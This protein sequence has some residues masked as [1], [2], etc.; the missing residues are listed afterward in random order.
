MSKRYCIVCG[1]EILAQDPS[2]VF[3]P[4]HGGSKPALAS[5]GQ[6]IE[7]TQT[8]KTSPGNN[9]V[10]KAEDISWQ[11]GQTLLETYKVIGLLGEGGMG[12][13]YHVHHT[14]WDMNLAVKQPRLSIFQNEKG[15]QNF[16]REAETWVNLGLY[17]HITSCYYVRS[18]LNIPHIFVE[19]LAGGSLE[20]WIQQREYDLYAGTK[21]EVLERILDIAVQFAWGLA[22]AHE[23]GLVHQ[24]VKP[25]NVLMTP[26][27][28]VKVTDFGLAKARATAGETSNNPT[29]ALVSGSMHTLAYR[30]PE[31][32]RGEPLDHK[33][34]IW[35][36]AISVLEMF[37]GGVNWIDGQAA[38]IS[39]ET[40]LQNGTW[41]K[42]A[43]PPPGLVSLLKDCFQEHPADRPLD[44]QVVSKRLCQIYQETFL[45]PYHREKPDPT[46]LRSNSLNNKALTMLD[47]GHQETA[48]RL[49]DQALEI[50]N[51]H[52]DAVYNQ[53]LLRWRNGVQNDQD[54]RAALRQI[55][56]DHPRN[57]GVESAFGWVY[58]EGGQ[59]GEALNHFRRAKKF[60]EDFYVDRGL[61][62]IE[63]LPGEDPNIRPIQYEGHTGWV[64]SVAFS[65][66]DLYILSGSND[67]TL[68]LWDTQTTDCI[69]TFEGH[70]KKIVQ[71]AFGIDGHTAF[72]VGED[73]DIRVWNLDSGD[74]IQQLRG[75]CIAVSP[76]GKT[77]LSASSQN[78]IKLWDI[79]SGQCLMMMR[80]HTGGVNALD[81]SPDGKYALSA[82][83]D[84]TIKLWDLTSGKCLRTFE[85][86]TYV[87]C[88]VQFGPRGEQA[89][90]GSWDST[91]RLW[92]IETGD[93]LS[94]LTGHRQGVKATA[95]HPTGQ[96]ALSAGSDR[97]LRLWDLRTQRCLSTIDKNI[98]NLID[99]AIS[100]DGRVALC[101][102]WDKVIT[103]W[104]LDDLLKARRTAP[105]R[106]SR[107]LSSSE[108]S[109]REDEHA[110]Y[111]AS[112]RAHLERQQIAQALNLIEK[113]NSIQGFKNN[114]ETMDLLQKAGKHC[115]RQAFIDC[116]IIQEFGGQKG[117]PY[118][119]SFTPDS[120]YLFSGNNYGIVS[121]W[122]V[123]TGKCI[124]E[125]EAED[126][127]G[128]R[129]IAICPDG[130]Y[131][132]TGSNRSATRS[133]KGGSLIRIWE[134]KSGKC[135][136]TLYGHKKNVESLA[137]SPD[138]RLLLSGSKDR[139]L[140]LW[141]GRPWKCLRSVGRHQGEVRA[142][143]FSPD[144]SYALSG[145]SD[146]V[147][148]LGDLRIGKSIKKFEGHQGSINS[149][150][151][152]PDGSRILSG[153]WDKTV[154]LWD[155]ETA[156]CLHTFEDHKGT[157][158]DVGFSPDGR[159]AFS[160][161]WDTSLMIWDLDK[162]KR[163]HLRVKPQSKHLCAAISPDGRYLI[164]ERLCLMQLQWD[165]EFPGWQDWDDRARPY[166]ENFLTIHTPYSA[167]LPPEP[168]P[169]YEQLK[170]ALAHQGKPTWSEADF[171]QLLVELGYHG[172]GW[173][174]PEGVRYKLKEFAEKR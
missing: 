172:F 91:L 1:E 61:R 120:H 106:Y 45:K 32:A 164:D 90:S 169:E 129:S 95:F 97:T 53:G 100:H 71:V 3:C 133:I 34:D 39:F 4:K 21:E 56:E 5:K 41:D 83:W 140:K 26:E 92:D 110:R 70:K 131:F 44:M 67:K 37:T 68:K 59:R 113:A 86:H 43:P 89:L 105:Y 58:L 13:V 33:T 65:S 117:V 18:I 73:D 62:L 162:S 124:R 40:C 35:S 139:T 54:L 52:L 98:D 57:A 36:W 48:S 101:A 29:H 8:S 50:D 118:C 75:R 168:D 166:L 17:T 15:K 137:F 84:K 126:K 108:A 51:Q 115:R 135:L 66:D 10:L 145:G 174:K 69:R 24:D 60:G 23:Q 173:L 130:K 93:C 138:G 136:Q 142:V 81:Y 163:I 121:M 158:Y 153:S 161:S 77:A 76:D 170:S 25:L 79:E 144:G 148:K 74:C 111:L 28:I 154:K 165:F 123:I 114:I 147:I 109:Q 12:K 82:S 134:I 49:F 116:E 99:V 96:Y 141:G 155:V 7:S 128:I 157:V 6:S 80:G 146:N 160:T 112:A 104:D 125:F 27:G 102:G 87:V 159:F 42:T 72:S 171:Q 55:K 156:E 22:Y 127:F 47:I 94:T 143:A 149:V 14:G 122:D 16:I 85:G 132:A 152:S 150:A 31:Q 107:A 20:D 9:R 63:S 78:N 19:Y 38:P 11:P 46:E 103:K 167:D 2:V 119:L 151:I 88:S 30:S 64:T